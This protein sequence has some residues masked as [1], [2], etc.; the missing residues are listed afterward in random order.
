MNIDVKSEL[1]D[2]IGRADARHAE[3]FARLLRVPIIRDAVL[4]PAPEQVSS[5][6]HVRTEVTRTTVMLSARFG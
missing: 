1:A 2:V 5:E 4:E 6:T 3:T